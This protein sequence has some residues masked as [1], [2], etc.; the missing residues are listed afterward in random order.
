MLILPF[1]QIC[2]SKIKNI[3][4]AQCQWLAIVVVNLVLSLSSPDI[5]G[6]L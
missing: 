1:F 3:A 4:G 5:I 6:H 2:Y